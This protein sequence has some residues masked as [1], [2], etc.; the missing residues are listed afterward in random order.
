MNLFCENRSLEERRDHFRK[1]QVGNGAQPVAGCRMTGD[2]DAEAAQLLDQPPDLGAGRTH[3]FGDFG[4]ARHDGGVLH[5]DA[6]DAAQA[7]IRCFGRG[8]RARFFGRY[9]DRNYSEMRVVRRSLFVLR[10][11]RDSGSSQVNRLVGALGS[12]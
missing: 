4:A 7:R 5:E 8:G 11:E 12:A 6:N 9:D 10:E 1:K 2:I 3:L